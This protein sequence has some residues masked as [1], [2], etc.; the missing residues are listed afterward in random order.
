MGAAAAL[1]SALFAAVP[2]SYWELS[3][4]VHDVSLVRDGQHRNLKGGQWRYGTLLMPMS[5]LEYVA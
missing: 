3:Y 4:R 1:F 2:A 5:P